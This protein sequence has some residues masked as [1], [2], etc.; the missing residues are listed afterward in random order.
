MRPRSASRPNQR[1][2]NVLL[3]PAPT[4]TDLHRLCL[5]HPRMSMDAQPTRR[6]RIGKRIK[7]IKW[8]KWIKWIKKIIRFHGRRERF[9]NLPEPNTTLP[10]FRIP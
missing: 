8:I 6:G 9:E 2:H 3:L 4:A 10:V 5:I 7:R 1:Y